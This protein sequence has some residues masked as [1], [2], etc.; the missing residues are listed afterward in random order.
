VAKRA[1]RTDAPIKIRAARA[2]DARAVRALC[3]RIWSDDYVRKAFP[4]W[5]RDRR[6]RLWVATVDGFVT[7]VAK[8]TLLGDDEA[9]L[10]GLRVDPRFRRRG[11]AS[12]L[13]RHRLDRAKRLGARTAR[14]DTADHNVAVQRIARHLGFRQVARFTLNVASAS[15]S[16][17]ARRASLKDLA[18]LWRL[19]IEGDGLVHEQYTVRRVQRWDIERAIRARRAFVAGGDVPRALALVYP[20]DD[21]LR[22]RHLAGRGPALVAL[23]RGLRGVAHAA[24]LRRVAAGLDRRH[25]RAAAT[26]GYR[27]PWDDSMLILERRM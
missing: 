27:D 9:W 20:F 4:E 10:H 26:A 6:G 18:A 1:A 8:L 15:P 13:A 11:I 16:E 19:R 5:V 12:A 2:A 23:L 14:L 22:V 25:W 17:A 24:G 7:G 21:R 3:A